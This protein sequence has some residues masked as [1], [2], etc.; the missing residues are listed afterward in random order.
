MPGPTARFCMPNC[1]CQLSGQLH[2]PT[3]PIPAQQLQYQH[4]QFNQS[5]SCQLAGE[6]QQQQAGVGTTMSKQGLNLCQ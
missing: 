6:L 1:G 5:P 2:S 4:Q 3:G